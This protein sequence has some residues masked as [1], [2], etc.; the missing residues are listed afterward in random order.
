MLN[1][2][3]DHVETF[4]DDSDQVLESSLRTQVKQL[5]LRSR[6]LATST[7]RGDYKASFHGSG[8]EFAESREYVLGDDTRFIDWNVTARMDSPWIKRYVEERDLTIILAVD[9]SASQLVSRRKNGRIGAAAE[10]VS[11]ISFLAVENHDR[12]GLMLFG[13]EVNEFIKPQHG[14]KHARRLVK[15]VLDQKNFTLETNIRK[16][17]DR[18][19]NVLRKKSII[20]LLSDFTNLEDLGSLYRMAKYH[21]V[22][23]LI[24]TDPIDSELPKVGLVQ[25]QS[26]EEGYSVILDT[27]DPTVRENYR[28]RSEG[29]S[30]LRSQKLAL[31]NV[32]EVEID[33]T[34][35]LLSPLSNYFKRRSAR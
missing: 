34:Q 23:A 5:E 29:F 3:K 2:R 11:L 20:F 25:I 1:W 13:K 15:A 4:L 14:E 32:G 28:L 33:V 17:C 30:H 24:L 22:I 9:T 26:I 27:T 18:L 31:A 19:T 6:D 35:D 21:D 7:L 16:A 10:L 8:V 12:V